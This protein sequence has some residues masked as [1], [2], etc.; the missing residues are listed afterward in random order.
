MGI[1]ASL[2]QKSKD[3]VNAI[4]RGKTS[5]SSVSDSS[6][7][8]S[9]L[10]SISSDND[11][12]SSSSFTKEAKSRDFDTK[13]LRKFDKEER[14]IIEGMLQKPADERNENDAF[15]QTIQLR[16][17]Q[18]SHDVPSLAGRSGR[19][20]GP[21]RTY[22]KAAQS[23]PNIL[24]KTSSV[25]WRRDSTWLKPAKSSYQ[26]WHGLPIHQFDK[27]IANIT[28]MYMRPHKKIDSTFIIHPEWGCKV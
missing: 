16:C 20:R 26:S 21:V 10:P 12:D 18:K 8:P 19:S 28:A 3:D 4:Q 7:K 9:I 13:W 2:A 15:K 17:R 27:D 14:R 1:R 6:R 23:Y 25:A 24:H 5:H 11:Q 22:E